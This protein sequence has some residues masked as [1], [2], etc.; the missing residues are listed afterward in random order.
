M[1]KNYDGQR[2]MPLRPESFAVSKGNKPLQL[3]KGSWVSNRL[4]AK[5]L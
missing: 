3:G 2:T 4:E 5:L 1:V